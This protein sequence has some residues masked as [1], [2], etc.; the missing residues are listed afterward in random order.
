M[1]PLRAKRTFPITAIAIFEFARAGLM[2]MIALRPWVGR[3]LDLASNTAVQVL[4]LGPRPYHPM[5]L[6][7]GQPDSSDYVGVLLALG[8]GVPFAAV[9]WGLWCMKKWGRRYAAASSLLIVLFEI[10]GLMFYWA[11]RDLPA[12]HTRPATSL[13]NAL[14][15]LCLNGI[16]FLYLGAGDGVAEAFGEK[17]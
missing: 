10:R 11:L 14:M 13:Q 17:E 1:E 15:G 2:L 8:L 4:T 9:G 7:G 3:G 5:R 16:I 12:S 6:I